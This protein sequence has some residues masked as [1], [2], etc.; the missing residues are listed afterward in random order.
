[1]KKFFAV[2]G[3]TVSVLC[4]ILLGFATVVTGY[5]LITLLSKGVIS[6]PLCFEFI[7]IVILLGVCTAVVVVLSPIVDPGLKEPYTSVF[8]NPEHL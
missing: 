1:M 7:G 2:M 3:M 5:R 6:L 8:D 4:A